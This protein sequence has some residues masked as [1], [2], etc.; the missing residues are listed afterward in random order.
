M[1]SAD[2]IATNDIALIGVDWGSTRLRAHAFDRSGRVIASR[3]NDRGMAG[4]ATP[5]AFAAALRELLGAGFDDGKAPLLL[6]GMVGARDGWQEAPYASL[7]ADAAT[8]AA[9]LQPLDFDGRRAAIV[10]GLCSAATGFSD[11][12]FSDVMRGEEVQAMGVPADAHLV[13][14]PGTH[15]KWLELTDNRVERFATYPT[16]ELYALLMRHSLIGRGLPADAWSDDGFRSGVHTARQH[17]DWQHQ[18]FGVRARQVRGAMPLEQLPAFLS[19]LL[20]GY[21]CTGA[22]AAGGHR[23]ITLVGGERIAALYVHALREFDVISTVI[24]GDVAFCNGLW[25]IAKAADYL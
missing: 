12:G 5:A 18:L 10:P 23:S 13:V 20:I 3:Q 6:A 14:A 22:L 19:G 2:R 24:D 11:T 9:V 8:L 16:G 25:R 7:P 17:P 4:L 15:S 1:H 21:E